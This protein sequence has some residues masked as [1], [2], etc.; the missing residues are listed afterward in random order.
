MYYQHSVNK[1]I[2]SFNTKEQTD[3]CSIISE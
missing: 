1:F 3:Q 2:L